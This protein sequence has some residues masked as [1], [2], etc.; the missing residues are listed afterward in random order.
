MIYKNMIEY[1]DLE[2][3]L[4]PG[5]Q[6]DVKASFSISLLSSK[7]TIFLILHEM[8]CLKLNVLRCIVYKSF[9]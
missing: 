6:S 4:C 8:C 5:L 3:F 7:F 2:L 1:G 9:V